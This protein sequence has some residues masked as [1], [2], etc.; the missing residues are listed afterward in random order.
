MNPNVTR[1]L[2]NLLGLGA[3][4]VI[5][6]V[7]WFHLFQQRPVGSG[8]AGPLVPAAAF[9]KSWSDRPTLLIGFGDSVTAGFG[10]TKNH[11]YF[12]RLVRN[13]E[14]EFSE[15]RGI[16][17]SAVFRNLKATNLAV[18]GSTSLQHVK[19]QASKLA[20]QPPDVQGIV[21]LTTGGNDIIH[22]YG[23]TPPREGAMYGATLEQAKPWL[24][25]FAKRLDEIL[26][27]FQETFPGGCD[28]FLAD[29]YDPTDG[30]GDADKAGLPA[31]KDCT[32]ILAAYNWIIHDAAVKHPFVH[33]VNIHDPFLGH[34]IHATQFWRATYQGRDPHYWYH[35]N[36]EDPNDRGY[37]ALR[38][39]F[40]IE[41]AEV[42]SQRAQN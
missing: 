2:R 24:E 13:P 30:L 15:M 28:V 11:S 18:S 7:V 26:L 5:G 36:L 25:N 17:L 37:D 3:A 29:I 31:W 38:R 12:D 6:F 16:S 32:A 14:N 33:L 10:A 40:L 27:K 22:N 42:F 21:V 39:L 8:P 4:G 34:G 20:R 23:K 19:L 35:V 1:R 9:S 41:M